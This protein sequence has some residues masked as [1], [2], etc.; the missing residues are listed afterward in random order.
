MPDVSTPGRV[1]MRKDSVVKMGS[2][3]LRLPAR[4]AALTSHPVGRE[5]L[6]DEEFQTPGEFEVCQKEDYMDK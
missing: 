2:V 4:D 1:Q 3:G 6:E 5:D